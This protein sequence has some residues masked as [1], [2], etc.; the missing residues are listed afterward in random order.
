MPLRLP[1]R[2]HVQRVA[3]SGATL[4]LTLALTLALTLTLTLTLTLILTLECM[5]SGSP[6][7]VQRALTRALC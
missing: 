2:V 3:A 5:Y 1:P 6:R 4:T 7:Q